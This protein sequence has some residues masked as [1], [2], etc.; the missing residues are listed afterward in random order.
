MIPFSFLSFIL[1]SAAAARSKFFLFNLHLVD[2]LVRCVVV[3]HLHCVLFVFVFDLVAYFFI[4]LLPISNPIS[5]AYLVVLFFTLAIFLLHPACM[6]FVSLLLAYH[7]SL[8]IVFSYLLL[9]ANDQ[10]MT[11]SNQHWWNQ[12]PASRTSGTPNYGFQLQ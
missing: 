11:G 7:Y 4:S 9:Y 5:D 8:S 6:L 1:V 10:E 12:T 2:Q 3:P